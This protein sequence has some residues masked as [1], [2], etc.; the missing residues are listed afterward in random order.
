MPTPEE[1]CELELGWAE[2][3]GRKQYTKYLT[4]TDPLTLPDREDFE[5]AAR[6]GLWIACLRQT[7]CNPCR[8]FRSF[9]RG[10]IS[11]IVRSII[12]AHRRHFSNRNV[13]YDEAQHKAG[14]APRRTGRRSGK[15]RKSRAKRDEDTDAF[16][17][18][19]ETGSTGP[20]DAK[21]VLNERERLG[22]WPN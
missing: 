9:A 3:F 4:A 17:H 15:V 2:G 12:K 7:E 5:A 6:E 14:R 8:T 19:R 21:S 10:F 22:Y 20:V 1:L 18:C 16:S 13:S 11:N